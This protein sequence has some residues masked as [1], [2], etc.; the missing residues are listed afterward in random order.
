MFKHVMIV[1]M[2]VLFAAALGAETKVVPLPDLLSV[3]QAPLFDK[4]QMYVIEG[5]SVN[6]YSLKDF[7]LVKKFGKKGEGPKEFMINPLLGPL[8]IS[9][10]TEDIVVESFG[11]LSWFT[12]NGIYKK[13]LKLPNPLIV[14]I[15]PF[16]KNYVG[17]K[18]LLGTERWQILTLYDDKIN[19]LKEIY[20]QPTWFQQGKGTRLLEA[21]AST[22]VFDNKLFLAWEKDFLIKVVDTDIKELYTIKRDEKRRAVTEDFKKKVI[23]YL[24]TAP[25]SRDYFEYLKPYIFPEFFPSIAA[26]IVDNNEL[27]VLTFMED[28]AENDECIIMDLKGKILKRVFLQL[29]MS[30][31]LLPY[32]YYIHDGSL[33]QIAENEEEEQWELHI[34]EI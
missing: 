29:K 17:V 30:T 16:G 18:I 7:K 5:T 22:A 33:Y 34:S 11:K 31:P 12:K 28:E 14:G 24:K 20:K 13:E 21:T 15:Q 4:T 8:F 3:K 26:I 2:V 10:H 25:E 9:V 1:F 27:Y 19:E 23:D 32:P 6:I